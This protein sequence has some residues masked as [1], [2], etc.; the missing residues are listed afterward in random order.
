MWSKW[1]ELSDNNLNANWTQSPGIYFI[2]LVNQRG[3][4]AK[5]PRI[6]GVE[7]KASYT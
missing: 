7:K 6:I 3:T 5:I 2:W 1:R 4:P